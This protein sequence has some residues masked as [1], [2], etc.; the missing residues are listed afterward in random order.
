MSLSEEQRVL[1]HAL[2]RC[3]V[4]SVMPGHDAEL[5]SLLRGQIGVAGLM[6]PE[7]H[8]G[9]GSGLAAVQLVMEELGRILAPVPM[10]ATILATQ[11]LLCLDNNGARERLLPRIA[12]GE[13][14]PALIWG[15]HVPDADIADV[16]LLL[17]G[18]K[19]SEVD[20]ARCRQ[21]TTMDP[22][23][24]LCTVDISEAELR[25][26]G[27]TDPTA[28]RDLACAALA[29][30]QVG[31]A[32]RCLELTVQYTS[33]RV[34]FGRAIGSFQ[35]LQHRMA[36]L[37]VLVETA[38]SAALAAT[39]P[40]RAAIA[41]VHCSE[42]YQRVAAEMIQLHGGIAITWEHDAHLYFK[43]AHGSAHLFGTPAE[44]LARIG[45]VLLTG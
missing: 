35:A 38:R 4:R 11:A 6:I 43:R 15:E 42:V 30:E 14:T 25:P 26:L 19:L 28:V 17:D 5:W 7:C 39:T 40:T 8:G 24:R 3:E 29:A 41:K 36:D 13:V 18:D 27:R 2:R 22:T 31:G 12:A 1:R 23:R 10:L 45:E 37:H 34:Q 33:R 20:G 21:L 16:L 9:T 32:A 44:H